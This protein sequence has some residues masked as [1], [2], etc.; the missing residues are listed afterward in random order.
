M[1]GR[2]V[3]V[4]QRR[5]LVPVAGVVGA[6]G[7][8]GAGREGMLAVRA[9]HVGRA[10]HG[11]AP[12]VVLRRRHGG[13]SRAVGV[14]AQV[15]ARGPGELLVAGKGAGVR[16]PGQAH[17]GGVGEQRRDHHARVVGRQAGV[18]VGEA[19]R[20]PGPAV[21]LQQQLGHARGRQGAVEAF[22]RRFGLLRGDR[23]ERADLQLV[24]A[25]PHVLQGVCLG[26]GIHL[27]QASFQQGAAFGQVLL[28][29][30]RHGD[31]QRPSL[32]HGR[33]QR[34][35]DQLVLDG[36]PLPAALTQ[37]S[38]PRSRSRNASRTADSQVRRCSR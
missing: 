20:E 1:P 6:Q 7:L 16:H 5:A 26:L 34:R 24:A 31:G 36:A 13:K 8:A 19:V 15:P 27:R 30:L 14:L 37:M 35:R 21:D 25:D 33:E 10:A 11:G 38:P 4:N 17:V 29:G 22:R 28:R 18:Q 12:R 32:A 9:G 2:G 23:L 3:G